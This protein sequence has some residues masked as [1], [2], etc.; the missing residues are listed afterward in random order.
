MDKVTDEGLRHPCR[1]IVDS[2]DAFEGPFQVPEAWACNLESARIVYLSSNPAISA[3]NPAS[4]WRAKR[5]AEGGRG[6]PLAIAAKYAA[7]SGCADA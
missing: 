4:M 5:V 6:A 7:C 1:K 2:Q 3:G